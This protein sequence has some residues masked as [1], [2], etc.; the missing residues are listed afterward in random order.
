MQ[1]PLSLKLLRHKTGLIT[2][3]VVI[4]A[5][6]LS[7]TTVVD[8]LSKNFEKDLA[9]RAQELLEGDLRIYSRRPFTE[10]E[11]KSIHNLISTD[12]KSTELWGFLSML[13]IGDQSK[14]VQVKA[15]SSTYPLIGSFAFRQPFQVNQLKHN[16]ILFPGELLTSLQAK[17]GDSL[18]LGS[19][20]FHIREEYTDRPGS[21]FQFWELGSRVYI[22]LQDLSGTGLDQKGSRIF[23]YNF[24]TIT[25][26]T[27]ANILKKKLDEAL[28]DPEIEITAASEGDNDISRSFSLIISFLK[29]IS[30]S[31]FLLAALGAAFFFHQHL[32]KERKTIALFTLLGGIRGYTLRL[33]GVQNMLLALMAALLSLLLSTGLIHLLHYVI[34]HWFNID[35]PS[36]LPL[37][38]IFLASGLAL[39]T[40]ILFSSTSILALSKVSPATL[41]KPMENDPLDKKIRFGFYILICAYLFFIAFHSSHS[42]LLSSLWL[43]CL[44]A[45]F[46]LLAAMAI[47]I[48]GILYG[49]RKRAS[50]GLK[51]WLG[52]F[53][54]NKQKSLMAFSTLGLVAFSSCLLP[55]L[56]AVLVQELEVP[57]GTT[58]PQLFLFDI[59]EEQF[60]PLRDS[61]QHWG[62]PLA[63][64]AP[65]IRARLDSVNGHAFKKD[66]G[67]KATL[68]EKNKQQFR[69]RGFNLSYRDSLSSSEELVA[70]K[71][72][73]GPVITGT[74]PEIS[75]EKEFAKRLDLKL[76]DTLAFDV[77][78]IEVNGLLTSLRKVRW[79]SFQPNFFALFQP[80]ALE[81]APKTF[82]ATLNK[83]PPKET[84]KLQTQLTAIFPN[85]TSLNVREAV[86]KSIDTLN[87]LQWLVQFMSFFALGIGLSILG[88]I[89]HAMVE[90]NQSNIL[91]LSTLGVTDRKLW[92]LFATEYLGF[93]LSAA[94]I[95]YGLSM[96][97]VVLINRLLWQ[98]P[99]TP[100]LSLLLYCL[101]VGSLVG[102][103]CTA[104]A[105]IKNRRKQLREVLSLNR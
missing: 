58:L 85:I 6:G 13:K 20:T 72:W 38:S 95:G 7:L 99:W 98:L 84:E 53:R 14:L 56:K 71:F 96:L 9:G 27:D 88:L 2:A 32:L 8:A 16:E 30:L 50:Y 19:Q 57:S 60:P 102:L 87:K 18:Q 74:L 62:Y 46:F 26:P 64:P 83:I 22:R 42:W 55:Q 1:W 49:Y 89:V 77:Q 17:V 43:G 52:N 101:A 23:R 78:G 59:Q 47:G 54:W 12:A 94:A 90:N 10:K 21:H 73:Q 93:C 86:L 44:G 5:L 97:A 4:Y 24:Y 15:M 28:S 11:Q 91:L 61:L 81:M 40:S 100:D 39:F 103:I 25:Q 68:E 35:I 63:F 48:H 34:Q 37:A 65:M 51:I 66:L 29:I 75:V 41:I 76:G 105:I 80:G 79:T 70:G 45:A 67:S 31:S 3:F 36:T 82:L 92:I 69:N 33:Y 104:Y